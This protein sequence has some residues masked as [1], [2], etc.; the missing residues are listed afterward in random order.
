MI[1]FGFFQFLAT[2]VPLLLIQSGVTQS[3]LPLISAI[4]FVVLLA[5]SNGAIFL[6]IR[7]IVQENTPNDMIG[8]V[9][10][11]IAV[12]SSL[13]IAIGQ[14]MTPLSDIVGVPVLIS[15]WSLFMIIVGL[16]AYRAIPLRG[17]ESIQV[18]TAD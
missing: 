2:L 8:R 12:V 16:I 11:A 4:P 5:A 14:L 3:S 13:A 9:F 1:G 18:E 17:G 15:F 10:G 6:G 7:V